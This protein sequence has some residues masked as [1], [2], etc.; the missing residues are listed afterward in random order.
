M[1][2]QQKKLR[3]PVAIKCIRSIGRHPTQQRWVCPERQDG[4]Q[5]TSMGHTKAINEGDDNRKVQIRSP[6]TFATDRRTWGYEA[7]GVKGRLLYFFRQPRHVGSALAPIDRRP[8]GW[9]M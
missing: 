8:G 4:V 5:H 1:L 7:V 3:S 2:R 6:V 9:E